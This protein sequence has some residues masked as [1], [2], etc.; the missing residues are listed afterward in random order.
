LTPVLRVYIKNAGKENIRYFLVIWFITNGVIN[1]ISKLTNYDF[2]VGIE[3]YF[4]TGYVGY[5]VLGYYLATSDFNKKERRLLYILSMV[6]VVATMIGTFV[7]TRT[8]GT[9]V[10][11]FNDFLF[12]N[13]I[14]MTI[15]IFVFI[16]SVYW[17]RIIKRD[18]NMNKF[19]LDVSTLSFGI[20]LVHILVLELLQNY[21][22]IDARITNPLISIP[23]VSMVI[24]TI[25]YVVIK[26]MKR[27]PIIEKF[28]P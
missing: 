8:K 10:D 18:S 19:I 17:E 24:M 23:L 4:F 28:V 11:Y 26:L 2:K 3:L 16:K 13:V 1:F 25:S 20:Y 27:L 9:Y 6:C 14:L 5:Y 12:P 7:L 15:G 21:Y 22:K